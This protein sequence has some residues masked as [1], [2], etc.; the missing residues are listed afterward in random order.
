ME[1][2]WAGPLRGFNIALI[3]FFQL[4]F[5]IFIFYFSWNFEKKKGWSFYAFEFVKVKIMLKNA[6][7][8]FS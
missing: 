3:R 5:M 4:L 6:D 7:N 1:Q 8:M 2:S